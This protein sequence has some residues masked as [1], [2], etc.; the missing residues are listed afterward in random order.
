MA[1]HRMP[2]QSARGVAVAR[3][4]LIAGAVAVGTL[5]APVASAFA[6]PGGSAAHPGAPA[7]APGAPAVAPGQGPL[8]PGQAV[9][10]SAPHGPV[11]P[12]QGPNVPGQSPAVPG[13]NRAVA[14]AHR[15]IKPVARPGTVR[16]YAIAPRTARIQTNRSKA[17]VVAAA[18]S[19]QGA[20]YSWG[21][22]GPNAFDCSGL[23]QWSMKQGGISV[24]R[25]SYGQLGGG[26]PVA[27]ADLRPGDVVIYNGGSHVAVY[28]GSGKVVQSVN[29][30]IPV[31]VSPLNEMA[32]YAARRY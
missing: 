28:I 3:G 19:K 32:F 26:T 8:A 31:K 24:P 4:A 2:Q 25:D 29:Y 15:V 14:I 16:D 1:K 13:Q 7:V 6:A 18:L 21:S 27:K 5:A 12:G 17:A 11:I 20:P 22:A 9:I 23:V 10:G 30:G